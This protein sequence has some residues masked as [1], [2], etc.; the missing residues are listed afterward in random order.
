MAH[1]GLFYFGQVLLWPSATSDRSAS[2]CS[3]LARSTLARC[4]KTAGELCRC[5]QVCSAKFYFGQVYFG[6][7]QLPSSSSSCVFLS[8]SSS[9][10]SRAFLSS[11]S[12]AVFFLFFFTAFLLFHQ[13][14]NALL[15]QHP[16]LITASPGPSSAGPGLWGRPV[17]QDDQRA[18]KV[19]SGG[20]KLENK[21]STTNST[22][23]TRHCGAF[24]GIHPSGLHPPWFHPS[25]P[26]DSGTPTFLG[27]GPPTF[28]GS[29]PRGP[30]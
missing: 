9:S 23:Q 17:S 4:H 22:E 8:S 18:S 26:L 6:H 12:C 29:H 5:G 28:L 16:L 20:P 11:L 1:F 27:S 24:F 3:M 25:R 30:L 19:D 15:F 7:F 13:P 21:K 14:L 2:A 10:S